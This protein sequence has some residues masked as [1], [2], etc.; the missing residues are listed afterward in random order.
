LV[1]DL[2]RLAT[3]GDDAHDRAFSD[4]TSVMGMIQQRLREGQS[5]TDHGTGARNPL[6]Q[7]SDQAIALGK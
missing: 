3:A 7:I 2:T 5:L 4:V 1:F 6:S